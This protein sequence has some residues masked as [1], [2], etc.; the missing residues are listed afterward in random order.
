MKNLKFY[1]TLFVL[2]LF[3]VKALHVQ[4]SSSPPASFPPEFQMTVT[5]TSSLSSPWL[6]EVH[7]VVQIIGAHPNWEFAQMKDGGWGNSSDCYNSCDFTWTYR[8]APR[9]FEVE[10]TCM[11]IVDDGGDPVALDRCVVVIEPCFGCPGQ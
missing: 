1:F 8:R 7:C 2:L 10:I 5:K 4:A 6:V 11:G 9:E 3:S